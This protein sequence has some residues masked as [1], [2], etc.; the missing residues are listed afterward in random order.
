MLHTI[1]EDLWNQFGASIDML[2][3]AI[4]RWPEEFWKNDHKFFYMAYHC[5]AFLDYYLT[6]HPE[7]FSPHN[8]FTKKTD[9]I[10]KNMVDDLTP[11]RIYTKNE[12]LDYLQYGR[13]KCRLFIAS[14]TEEKM[15]DRWINQT[16][17][18]S[19]FEILLYNMRHV[20]HHAAQLNLLLRQTVNDAP[21]WVGRAKDD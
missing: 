6:S 12:L 10:T 16:K 4:D 17:N 5:L 1:K 2:K 9:G 7:N 15:N 20:Q 8:A 11:D 18:Y 21:R 13:N 14:L 3:N 19:V